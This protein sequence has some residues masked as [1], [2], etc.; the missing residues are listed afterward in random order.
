MTRAERAELRQKIDAAI[1]AGTAFQNVCAWCLEPLKTPRVAGK[2]YCDK[3]CANN[4]YAESKRLRKLSGL[5][6]SEEH[7]E[8]AR[9]SLAA[10]PSL[11]TVSLAVSAD[12]N[13]EPKTASVLRKNKA[14]A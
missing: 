11:D 6:H 8:G 4:A 9:G 10:R 3:L 1:R 12:P 7:A 14:A 2:K 13:T 5:L